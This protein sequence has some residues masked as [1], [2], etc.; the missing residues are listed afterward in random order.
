MNGDQIFVIAPR[1]SPGANP[2]REPATWQRAVA[3]IAF[4]GLVPQSCSLVADAVA[5]TVGGTNIEGC[6]NEIEELVNDLYVLNTRTDEEKLWIFGTF[7]Q[8]RCQSRS[9][10]ETDNWTRPVRLST[11]WSAITFRRYMCLLEIVAARFKNSEDDSCRV[12]LLFQRLLSDLDMVY[13]AAVKDHLGKSNIAG[14][15]SWKLEVREKA[16]LELDLGGRRDFHP[17]EVE[18]G[19]ALVARGCFGD[20]TG[21]P[22]RV[23]CPGADGEV[24]R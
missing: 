4:G 10:I 6:I 17:D 3:G 7:V 20:C 18:K 16:I 19:R 21:N 9:W 1:D 15:P 12:E 11:P 14:A 22:C 23:G 2:I 13:K 24:E 5:F 8:E